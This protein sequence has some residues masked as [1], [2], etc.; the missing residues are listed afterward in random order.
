MSAIIAACRKL[1]HTIYASHRLRSS[2]CSLSPSRLSLSHTLVSHFSISL[3]HLSSLSIPISVCLQSV[4]GGHAYHV[5]GDGFG[6]ASVVLGS[7]GSKANSRAATQSMRSICRGSGTAI[8]LA[9]G[10]QQRELAIKTRLRGGGIAGFGKWFQGQFPESIIKV[11][12]GSSSQFDHVCF[13]MNGI[14]H[15]ACRYVRNTFPSF[16]SPLSSLLPATSFF[17][18]HSEFTTKKTQLHSLRR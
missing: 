16:L 8:R 1:P 12:D 17:L 7:R 15:S 10:R 18:P 14:L 11:Q 13:D 2:L 6:R 4:H 3:I 9:E 5:P